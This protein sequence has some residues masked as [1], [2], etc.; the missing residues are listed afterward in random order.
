MCSL[1]S[2]EQHTL[3][4][5]SRDSSTVFLLERGLEYVQRGCYTEGAALL[6]LA[7][8]QLSPGQIDLASVLDAF[9]QGYTSYQRFQQTLQEASRRFADTCVEQKAR[10]DAL[11]TA[12]PRLIK[13]RDIST[14]DRLPSPLTEATN[15]QSLLS[16]SL[17]SQGLQEF[18]SPSI[19]QPP[20]RGTTSLPDLFITCFGRFEVRQSGKP[21]VLC[22]SR[23]GQSIL[24]Y[25]VAR[26]GHHATS[27]TLQ[28]MLW[29]E[30]EPEVA[31]NKLHIA[32][33]ALRRSLHGGSPCE[34]GCSYI[35]FKK[36]VY[37]LNPAAIIRTDVDEFLHCY[38]IG[39]QRGEERV[40]F[41]ERACRLY[42]GPFL[43][44]DLYADWSFL[45]RE[46]FSQTYHTM[47]G[48]LTDHYLKIKRYENAA[49]WATAILK[50]NRCDEAAHQQLMQIY[51]A[52]GRRSEAMQQYQHCERILRQELAVQPLPETVQ[53][54]QTLLRGETS[55]HK[56]A[57][58]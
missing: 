48:V 12:L 57:Q 16:P 28:A 23:N 2:P 26:S 51:A 11:G 54:F 18:P 50:E 10:A 35:V 45:L 43:L 37:Y 30:D 13:E 46:Q 52:Q 42:T 32:I 8:E 24:R 56:T 7:R 21:L 55:P 29:P 27:D 3:A 41:Y 17:P 38:Q 15:H 39:Q 36:R 47:C 49:K 6:T 9:L 14:A 4:G 1:L 19:P 58:I 22:S 5:I 44:E 40:A 25:L 53:L 20:I 33:S 34:P 31:Q